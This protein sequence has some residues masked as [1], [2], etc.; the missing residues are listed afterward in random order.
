MREQRKEIKEL[1]TKM[2]IVQVTHRFPPSI[3][4]IEMHVLDISTGLVNNGIDVEILSADLDEKKNNEKEKIEGISV[5]RFRS[6]AP[7]ESFYISPQIYFYLKKNH[8]DV[9]HAHNYRALP[10]FFASLSKGDSKFIF[11]PHIYGFQRRGLMHKIYKP[12]GNKIFKSADK[13]I[14]ISNIEKEW[15]EKTFDVDEKIKYIPHPIKIP[16]KL[17]L[18]LDFSRDIKRIGFVGRLATEKNVDILINAFKKVRISYPKIELLLV[19]DGYQRYDLEKIAG[20]GIQFLGRLSRD[21]TFKFYSSVD[22]IVLPSQFEVAPLSIL[23]AMA[24]SIP[25]IATPVGELPYILNDEK[26]CLFTKIGDIDDL[27]N[28]IIRLIEDTEL[29]KQISKN[30]R[31]FVETNYDMNK[32]IKE[33]INI[34]NND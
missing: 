11:T 20:P 25:V 24:R 14:S 31:T 10:A 18:K 5:K 21:E 1:K 27:S 8:Y 3:G 33:Y 30:G 6:F 19:G 17:D 22:L 28:K 23:E 12:F 29:S 13:I 16:E 9:I 7:D 34:Y 26:E 15:L 2:K 32:V 4:G